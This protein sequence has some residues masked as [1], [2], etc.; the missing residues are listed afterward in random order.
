MRVPVRSLSMLMWM[1]VGC[2][3]PVAEG[4]VDLVSPDAWERGDLA[5]DPIDAHRPAEVNCPPSTWGYEDGRLEV[6]TGAC[7]FA[8]LV[9][10]ALADIDVGDT[11]SVTAWHQGLDAAIPAEGH[12]ALVIDGVVVWDT[13]AAIPSDPE[14]FSAEIIL[15]EPVDEGAEVG[16]HLHNHGYNSWSVGTVRRWPEEVRP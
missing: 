11:V 1:P 15:D 7:S 9:Q 14:V 12:L 6:Q 13:W 3:P 2:A 5:T 8:W 10:P 16:V 4:P